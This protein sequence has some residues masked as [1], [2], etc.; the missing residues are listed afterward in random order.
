MSKLGRSILK[1]IVESL[2]LPENELP[3][4]PRST[5]KRLVAGVSKKVKALKKW[6]ERRAKGMCIDP[7]L[8]CTNTQIQSLALASPKRRKDLEGMDS[9]KTWQI[10]MFGNEICHLLKGID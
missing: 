1:R 4:F 5:R 10:E 6:R 9:I 2:R 3:S 8:V 7:Y